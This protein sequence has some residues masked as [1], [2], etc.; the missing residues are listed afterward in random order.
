MKKSPYSYTPRTAN[1]SHGCVLRLRPSRLPRLTTAGKAGDVTSAE[2]P[3]HHQHER[4]ACADRRLFNLRVGSRST[5]LRANGRRRPHSARHET[6]SPMAWRV[7]HVD[8]R[9]TPLAPTSSL[10]ARL[11]SA[12]PSHSQQPAPHP[13]GGLVVIAREQKGTQS[14]GAGYRRRHRA[15]HLPHIW[16]R[17][18]GTRKMEAPA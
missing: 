13:P 5:A 2:R 12:A 6:V 3:R 7:N 18:T 14:T 4:S 10:T 16:E 9:E 17:S 11:S 1:V 8:C 15:N